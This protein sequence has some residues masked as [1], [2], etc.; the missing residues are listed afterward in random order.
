MN[1]MRIFLE[2]LIDEAAPTADGI[3]AVVAQVH[4]RSGQ[5]VGGAVR[6]TSTPGVFELATGGEEKN[7]K[8]QPTGRHIIVSVFFEA[9]ALLHIDFPKVEEAKL[10]TPGGGRI[11]GLPQH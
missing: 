2:K 7:E 6:K 4:F 1:P 5:F 10:I 8:G 9:E 3:Q 11:I